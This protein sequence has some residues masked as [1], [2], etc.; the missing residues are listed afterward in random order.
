MLSSNGCGCDIAVEDG[1]MVGIRGR[2]ADVINKGRLGPKGLFA[3]WQGV[4]NKDRPTKPLI[5]ENGRLV[6]TDW[7]TA[8]NAIQPFGRNRHAWGRP[9]APKNNQCGSNPRTGNAT[10]V[11]IA[12]AAVLAMTGW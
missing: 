3:S 2:E 10:D 5:R 9:S 11:D 7:D 4:S 8:M 12:M 1:V 6:E